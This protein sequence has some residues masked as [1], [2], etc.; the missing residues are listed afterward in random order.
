MTASDKPFSLGE[1]ATHLPFEVAL[2]LS[3]I[4]FEQASVVQITDIEQK[5]KKM[6]LVHFPSH[7]GIQGQPRKCLFAYLCVNLRKSKNRH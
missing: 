5:E 2:S 4:C 6:F 1:P 7:L 3:K